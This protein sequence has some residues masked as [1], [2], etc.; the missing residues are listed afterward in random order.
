M[1]VS[2]A[3]QPNCLQL[4]IYYTSVVGVTVDSPKIRV[5]RKVL[6]FSQTT[7]L[8]KCDVIG[9]VVIY[10]VLPNNMKTNHFLNQMS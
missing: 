2:N 7:C 5:N 4:Y 1:Y 6:G 8:R 3:V 10:T 9:N